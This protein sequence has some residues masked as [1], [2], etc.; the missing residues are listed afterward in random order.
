VRP[1]DAVV[2]E[3][4]GRLWVLAPGTGAE[5]ARALATQIADAV[6]AAAAPHGMP[7]E[8]AVGVAACPADGAEARALAARAD[9][10]LFAARAAG[11]PV[12]Q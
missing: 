10:R 7:L 2:R 11:V 8:A 5:A 9:E 1:G 4:A 12:V 3:R 6:A